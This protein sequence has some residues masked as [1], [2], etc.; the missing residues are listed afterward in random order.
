MSVLS[1]NGDAFAA[2]RFDANWR[3]SSR[4][5]SLKSVDYE[6]GFTA[7]RYNDIC[8]HGE[9]R[10]EIGRHG[11]RVRF[12]R[13]D[14]GCMRR[15]AARTC[16]GR[17]FRPHRHTNHV[18]G[19][20][21]FALPLVQGDRLAQ[22]RVVEAVAAAVRLVREYADRSTP[23]PYSTPSLRSPSALE[24]RAIALALV[25]SP[26]QVTGVAPRA[27]SDHGCCTYAGDRRGE[28]TRTPREGRG[29]RWARAHGRAS[30]RDLGWRSQRQPCP[31]EHLQRAVE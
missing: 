7:A 23:G 18:G 28:E 29:R 11:S 5:R 26:T 20:H 31:P 24:R 22:A 4:A 15:S 30:P 12:H 9:G 21:E 6:T 16:A 8:A 25:S 3:A 13:P 14:D 17:R 1:Q 19:G 2:T 10:S 27:R